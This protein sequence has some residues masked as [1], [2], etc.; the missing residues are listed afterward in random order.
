M[1]EI[2]LFFFVNTTIIMWVFFFVKYYF[3]YTFF[4]SRKCLIKDHPSQSYP[5]CIVWRCGVCCTL[6]LDPPTTWPQHFHRQISYT[7]LLLQTDLYTVRPRLYPLP[8]VVRKKMV[9]AAMLPFL[10]LG[11][12][13]CTCIRLITI[14]R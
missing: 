10:M 9:I 1:H 14:A 5:S 6:L 8:S 4:L 13:F 12:L 7:V 3:R 11:F 2:H